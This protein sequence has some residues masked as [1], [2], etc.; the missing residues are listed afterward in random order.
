MASIDCTKPS[1]RRDEKHVSLGIWCGLCWRFD[2]SPFCPCGYHWILYQ[3]PGRK[4]SHKNSF[5]DRAADEIC[6]YPTS[7]LRWRHNGYDSVSN[8]QPRDCFLNRLFKHRS[9]KTSKL[10]V[11][12]LCAGNSPEADEFPAQ[13]ASNAEN[14]SIWWRHHEMSWNGLKRIVNNQYGNSIKTLG[15][16]HL[17]TNANKRPIL[18]KC[19]M[20]HGTKSG[21]ITREE[22]GQSV[23]TCA[24]TNPARPGWDEG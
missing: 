17:A 19:N 21:R 7:T 8:H 20:L 22:H 15:D 9:K 23:V 5:E 16:G 24:R 12:G 18:K 14:A 11:T 4:S 6:G 13:M 10:R 2:G 3:H 1:A